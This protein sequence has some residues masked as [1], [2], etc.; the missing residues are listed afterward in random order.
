[1]LKF[2]YKHND[3]CLELV[4]D[5][6]PL[7]QSSC[8]QQQQQHHLADDTVDRDTAKT[9]HRRKEAD[10]KSIHRRQWNV[11]PTYKIT[12]RPRYRHVAAVRCGLKFAGKQ[13]SLHV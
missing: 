12:R 8:Q 3:I 4:K 11:T 5:A 1:L 13:H 6:T 7:S 2:I 9:L 10:D